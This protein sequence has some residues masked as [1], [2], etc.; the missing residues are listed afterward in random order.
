VRDRERGAVLITALVMLLLLTLI[1]VTGT[2][3]L[4]LDEQMSSNL[5]DHTVALEAAEAALLDGE[6]FVTELVNLTPFTGAGGLLG[7]NDMEPTFTPALVWDDGN[8]RRY[9][10]T[11]QLVGVQ[12]PRWMVKLIGSKATETP[13]RAVGRGYGSGGGGGTLWLFRITAIGY[14]RQQRDD[15]ADGTLPVTAVVLQSHYQRQL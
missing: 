2:R 7:I 15:G 12:Q 6:A 5:H 8:S 13:S 14:G 3:T 9:R 1:G 4:L 11:L 10:S